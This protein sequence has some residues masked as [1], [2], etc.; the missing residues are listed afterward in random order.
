MFGVA[1]CLAKARSSLP[2]KEKAI[3][4]RE[5]GTLTKASTTV[6]V[7]L[8]RRKM[9][10]HVIYLLRTFQCNEPERPLGVLQKCFSSR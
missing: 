4:G 2:I 3:E 7:S 6:G 10:D 8:Q 5:P 1:R 9:Y